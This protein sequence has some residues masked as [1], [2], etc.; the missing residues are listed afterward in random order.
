MPLVGHY[1]RRAGC[2]SGDGQTHDFYSRFFAP[3]IGVTEDPVT[4]SAHS[5]LAAYWA[6]KMPNKLEF[7][8][9]QC[10]P[11]GG[12]LN[13]KLLEEGGKVQLLG[14]AVVIFSGSLR[15]SV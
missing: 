7:R 15:L 12:E 9:R 1:L 5:V 11:R 6:S 13:V 3:W 4:G 14:Q 2:S 10:S 8:A